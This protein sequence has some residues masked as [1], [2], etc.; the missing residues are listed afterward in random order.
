MDK[1]SA[2]RYLREAYIEAANSPDPS[3]QVG[4]ILVET[5][6]HPQFAISEQIVGRGHN[7]FP[8]EL[9]VTSEMIDD[10]QTKL[11]FIEHAERVALFNAVKIHANLEKCILYTFGRPCADCARAIALCGVKH[12]VIHKQRN[13]LT[14]ERWKKSCD[15]GLKYMKDIGVKIEEYDGAVDGPEVFLD[16]KLWSPR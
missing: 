2:E 15:A 9:I 11:L 8:S 5:Q 14:S 1:I 6:W 10:R 12:I 16:G 4:A 7:G 3:T 13:D